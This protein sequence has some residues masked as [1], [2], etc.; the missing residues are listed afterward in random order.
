LAVG[1]QSHS[2]SGSL[3]S[4]E[5]PLSV[6]SLS[7]REGA[8]QCTNLIYA[9]SI[10]VTQALETAASLSC[11][12]AL[13]LLHHHPFGPS[14]DFGSHSGQ[15][16]SLPTRTLAL[17][18]Q[19]CQTNNNRPNNGSTVSS[20]PNQTVLRRTALP[21]AVSKPVLFPASPSATV[22]LA[23][24]RLPPGEK[25]TLFLLSALRHDRHQRL[26]SF[27]PSFHSFVASSFKARLATAWCVCK[28]G[29]QAHTYFPSRRPLGHTA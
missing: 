2:V 4:L 28:V 21:S 22:P 29:Q 26:Y 14:L 16:R 12:K 5:L 13:T 27:K 6:G 15:C 8:P 20:S 11:V 7:G 24:R 25:R 3:A 19:L 9:T 10:R 1:R 18:L 23:R 17:L